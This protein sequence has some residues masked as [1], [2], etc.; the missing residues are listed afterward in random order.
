MKTSLLSALLATTVF[1]V[2][3]VAVAQTTTETSV[4]DTQTPREARAAENQLSRDEKR[5]LQRLLQ[6]AGHYNG[7]IDGLFGRGTRGSM[8][9]WQGEKGFE[10]TG[11]LTTIQRQIL[12][13]DYNAI[14]NGLGMALHEDL[15]AGVSVQ[16]P[17]GVLGDRVVDAPFARF[18]AKDG[19]TPQVLLISQSGDAVRLRAMF[20][21]L[22]TLELFPETGDR[23]V[24][25]KRFDITATN[26]RIHTQ[27]FARLENGQIKGVVLVWPAG[28]DERRTRVW[29]EIMRSFAVTD[30]VLP[31]S[32]A[33]SVDGPPV[34]LLAGLS[35][36]KPL[37]S[38]SG[39]FVSD[40]G[41]VLTAGP[42]FTSCG[43][44]ELVD[45]AN[46]T[47]TAQDADT[48]LAVLRPT[49]Q[50]SPLGVATIQTAELS[51]PS[52]I[53]VAGFSYSGLLGAPT[54]SFGTLAATE[55]LDGEAA[56]ARLQVTTLAGDVG[57]PVLD[58]GGALAGILLP[59][60]N[61]DRVLPDGVQFAATQNNLDAILGE[62]G[63]NAPRT[64]AAASM[65]APMMQLAAQ[66]MTVLVQCWE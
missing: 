47:V 49:D 37:F 28:D 66:D 41:D 12:L 8:A 62:A 64:D 11:I 23:E 43:R 26:A 42:D 20:D 51:V 29:G 63:V 13:D 48:G 61:G 1:F 45:N 21:I 44:V 6:W 5:D 19:D 36:R 65:A 16:L 24:S 53:A 56:I 54:L 50:L 40:R 46:A 60:E 4:E 7:A 55:G 9:S 3:P 34:D 35:V 33:L 18:G 25:S 14:L 32:A 10:P 38:V 30:A 39:V 31:D 22:Q 58:A 59:A 52:E 27:G 17:I 15:D 57:G 2:A